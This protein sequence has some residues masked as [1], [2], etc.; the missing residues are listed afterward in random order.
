[1]ATLKKRINISVSDAVEQAVALLAKRDDVPQATKV[2]EL[3]ELALEL[4]EDTFFSV[5]VHKRLSKKVAWK[6]HI[7][8]WR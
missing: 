2:T 3:L 5:I 7:E 1:M 8:A 4:E 6:T